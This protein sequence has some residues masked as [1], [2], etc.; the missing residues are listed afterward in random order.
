MSDHPILFRADMVRAILAGAKTQTRR[1][2]KNPEGWRLANP[3][4]NR[5]GCYLSSAPYFSAE[6]DIVA[7]FDVGDTMWVRE[8]WRPWIRGWS[9]HV[10]Y[11]ADDARSPALG[12]DASDAAMAL[13][14]KNGGHW[15]D[16]RGQNPDEVNWKPSIFMPR[17]ASRLTFTVTE[18]RAER[19]TAITPADVLAEGFAHA[20]LGATP[21]DYCR[22][23]RE[24][25]GLGKGA[26]PWVWAYTFERVA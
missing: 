5:I 10:Q 2:I 22:G 21:A 20:G 14:E 6:K 25:N 4:G 11:K 9:S 26:D 17:W 16:G 3:L 13:A 7:R 8:T 12:S 23:F 19:L 1:Q 24:I 18:V 15:D